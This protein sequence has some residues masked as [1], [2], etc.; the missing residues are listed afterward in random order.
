MFVLKRDGRRERVAFDKI[1][2]RINKLC[3]GL[4]S[5]FV[6]AAQIAQKVI[7][8]VYQGVTTVELDNLAA[9]TA[10][11]LT[12]T[13][14]DYAT[15]AARIAVSN[16]H[17]ETTKQFST[18]VQDL[19]SY[20]HPKTGLAQPMISTETYNTI[21][22]HAETLNAA[23]IYDRDYSYNY[24]GFK[25]LERSYLLKIDGMV[26]E[27]PQHMLMRVSVGIHGE[28]IDAAIETYN[29]LSERFFTHASPTLF[30][31]GTPHP[32]LSSCFLLT[33]KE[34]S[35]E[36]IYETL[37]SCAMISKSAGGIGINIHKIRASGSY[38]A[39]TN[40]HSNG[41]I[42]MLRVFNNTARYVDQGGNK[43]P[44]AFAIYL[45]PWHADIFDFLDLKKNTGKEENRARDLFYAMWICDLFM[46]RVEA[47][48]DWSLFCPSEAPGLEDC[49]GEKFEELYESYERK[50]LAR[51]VIKAQKLW[52]AIIE[53]Q[54]ETGTPYMLYKDAC[55][56]KS[57]Q[58]NLGTIKCSNLCTEIVEYTSPDEIAV[59]N[60]ASISLP[61]FV[62]D[63]N[64]YDFE[65]LRAVTKVMT[66][67]LN[68]VIDINFY[69]VIEAKNSNM[70]HRP[71][72]LGVQGLADAFIKMRLP[73][74]SAGAIALNKKIFENM[75]YAA[76][77]ASCEIAEKDGAYSTYEGSPM[78]KGIMQPDMWGIDLSE[79]DLDWPAL[80][81]K[82]AKFGVRNSLLM[83]PMPTAST[84]QILG[85]NECFEPYTS[86]I[87]TRRVLA[88]EFQIVNPH[89]L[90]DLTELNL[91]NETMKNRIIAENGS[92]QR[93]SAI[94]ADIKAIYKTVW[95]ISQK[96]I[97]D[98][99]A[100]RG[101]FIDQSQSLNIH[102][103]DPNYG[104]LT[105]MH[106][107]GWK[108]GL[109][110]GMYY[111]RTRP[112]VDAIKFT[113]DAEAVKRERAAEDADEQNMAAITCSID[114]RDACEMCSGMEKIVLASW[115]LANDLGYYN[116]VEYESHW[117]TLLEFIQDHEPTLRRAA[118]K[119]TIMASRSMGRSMKEGTLQSDLLAALSN[120]DTSLRCTATLALS[121]IVAASCTSC[122]TPPPDPILR[123]SFNSVF[124]QFLSVYPSTNLLDPATPRMFDQSEYMSAALTKQRVT[125][126][127][128]MARFF[129]HSPD[130]KTATFLEYMDRVL[131]MLVL[132][133]TNIYLKIAA[134][135]VLANYI[136]VTNLNRRRVEDKFVKGVKRIS[137]LKHLDAGRGGGGGSRGGVGERSLSRKPSAQSIVEGGETG[138][139]TPSLHDEMSVKDG[140]ES[141]ST[142]TSPGML[143][144]E[145]PAKVATPP[146]RVSDALKRLLVIEISKFWSVWFPKVADKN[147][148]LLKAKEAAIPV[149][150]EGYALRRTQWISTHESDPNVY[151]DVLKESCGVPEVVFFKDTWNW[152]A[153]TLDWMKPGYREAV[154][155]SEPQDVV[156]S[157]TPED[158]IVNYIDGAQLSF[159]LNPPMIVFNRYPHHRDLFL[160][161]RSAT[162]D[163]SFYLQASPPEFFSVTPSFGQILRGE[164]ITLK[165]YNIPALK[166]Y[167]DVIEFGI[168]PKNETRTAVV[169]LHSNVSIECPCLAL[170]SQSVPE[171]DCPFAVPFSWSQPLLLPKEK[172]SIKI[173]FK[174][175]ADGVFKEKL[176]II[177]MGGDV[178]SVDLKGTGGPTIKVSEEKLDMGPT[179][180]Y[181]N[182]V[183]RRIFVENKDPVNEI[184][185]RFHVSTDEIEVNHCSDL[186]LS[187]GEVK[188]VNVSFKSKFTGYRHE[189][190]KITAPNAL[191][192]PIAVVAVSGPAVLIP[193]ME[194]I[195]FPATIAGAASSVYIPIRNLSSSP[196]H[197]QISMPQN[198][199]FTIK[200]IEAENSVISKSSIEL[201]PFE[202]AEASGCSVTVTAHMTAVLQIFF[203]SSATGTFRVQLT[204]STV[205]PKKAVVA[206]HFLNAVSINES[207]MTRETPLPQIRKFLASPAREKPSG[208]FDKKAEGKPTNVH[209]KTSQVFEMDPPIQMCFGAALKA[210][211]ENIWEYVTLTNLVDSVQ[212]Y[213]LL[214]SAPF[215]TS[216]PLE[217][218][219]EPFTSL[220]IPLRVNT[221]AFAVESNVD[222]LDKTM[223]G[224]VAAFDDAFGVVSSGIIGTVGDLVAAEIRKDTDIIQF[225]PVRSPLELV[226]EGRVVAASSK[227]AARNVGDENLTT[228]T[229]TEWCPFGVMVSR[230]NLKP[231]DY[232]TVEIHFQATSSG[233]YSGRLMMTYV[234][235]VYHIINNEYHRTRVKRD[236]PSVGVQCAVGAAEIEL[237]KEPINFGDILNFIPAE[238]SLV[239]HN[240]QMIESRTP[241]MSC[242]PFRTKDSIVNVPKEDSLPLSVYF[243]SGKSKFYNSF[244]WLSSENGTTQTVPILANAGFSLLTTNLAEPLPCEIDEKEDTQVN[245]DS[246]HF[247]EFGFVGQSSSKMKVLHL[248]N[249]GTFEMIVKNIT[250]KDNSH[251]LWK[252][253]DE[254]DSLKQVTAGFQEDSVTFW[255]EKEVDWD[256]ID[257]KLSDEKAGVKSVQN[258]QVEAVKLGKKKRAS[259][260]VTQNV[261]ANQ[262]LSIHKQFPIRIAPLQ[263]LS[264]AIGFGGGKTLSEI[265]FKN[266]GTYALTWT[267]EP[268]GIK[269]TALPK[270]NPEPLP[271]NLNAIAPP[272]SIFPMKGV[273]SP[274]ATQVVEVVFCPNLPEY[275]VSNTFCL[276]TE[277]FDQKDII[278]RGIGASSNLILDRD[279]VD[280]DPEEGILEGNG[281]VD[282][283]VTFKPMGV[284]KINSFLKVIPH[285]MERYKL[286]PMVVNIL[287][288]A[289]YPDI[290]VLTKVVDFGTALFGAENTKPIVIENMGS[291]DADIIFTCS[292]PAISLE[293]GFSGAVVLPAKSRKDIKLIY[294][295]QQ[296]ELLNV[297][298]FVRSSDTR[299]DHFM[300]QLRGSV[301][302]PKITFQPSSITKEVNFGVCAV[303]GHQKRTF[304]MKNE[305]NINLTISMKIELLSIVYNSNGVQRPISAKTPA[306]VV[307][308]QSAILP[309]GEE[310]DVTVIFSPEK[311]AIYEYKMIFKYDFKQVSTILRGVGGRALFQIVSPLRRLDFGI[312]RLNRVFRKLITV[313]NTGNLGVGFHVRPE[314]ATRD[315]VDEDMFLNKSDAGTANHWT[316]MLE[317]LGVKIINPDGFCNASDK[318]DIILEYFPK[319]EAGISFRLRVYFDSEHED[320]D[321]L[322]SA[323]EP[324]L[325][326]MNN[327]NEVLT[328]DSPVKQATL[329]LG[330]HPINLEYVTTLK[331]VNDGPF[332]LDFLIQ[333]IGI[334]EFDIF[335]LRGYIEPQSSM[336]LKIFFNPTSESKF[337]VVLKVLWEGQPLRVNIVGSGGIGKLEVV[338]VEDKDIH[339]RCLDFNM[340]PFNSNA[341]KRFFLYNIGLVAVEVTADSDNPDYTITKTGDPFVFQRGLQRSGP[342]KNAWN[343]WSSNL[344]FTLLP[345]MGIE[346]GAKFFSRSP[347]TV[348]GHIL[349]YS[350][351]CELAIPMRG[352]GGTFSIAHRGELS[353]GDIASNYTYRRKLTV[354]N[355]G[356]IPANISLEW[357]IV[358]RSSEAASSYV[359][360]AEVYNNT[361]PR[362][363]F[364]R[365]DF[366][367]EN[368]ITASD[369]KLTAKD[370]WKLIGKIIRKPNVAGDDVQ[371]RTPLE[372][373]DAVIA[374]SRGSKT[375]RVPGG[376]SMRTA[377]GSGFAVKKLVSN[378]YST[379]I[380]RRQTFFHLITSTPVSSQSTA[381][382]SSFIKVEP[383]ACVLPSYG[384]VHLVVE[385]NL[386]TEDTFLAT[387]LI[388]S[389]IACS[390]PHEIT[391]SA[392][393]KAVSIV[394]DDTRMLNFYRQPLGEPEI[395]LRS[396]TNVGH[397][398]INWRI[399]NTNSALSI[400]PA[401]GILKIGQSQQVQFIFRPVDE[402]I[403]NADIIFEPDCSQHIRLKMSGGGGFAKASLS[404]Y[405]RFD[406]GHC[407]IGKD[408]ISLLPITNE[409]NALLHLTRFDLYETDTFF[410]GVD[411]PTTRISLFPGQSFNLAL[412]FNPHEE[413]PSAGRLVIGTSSESWEIELI[414]LGR[415]AVLIVSKS[416]LEFTDCLIGNS[417]ERK[418]GLK[419]VGD[420]NYPVTFT[421]E[422]EFPDLEFI[423]PSLVIN[424][425]SENSV[426]ISYTPTMSIKSTVVM[427]VS[428]P[429]S[430]HKIPIHLHSGTATLEFT[431]EELDFGMFERVTRP[432]LKLGI[433]NTGSV[434]TS[435]IVRD[436]VKPSL[437]Q[438]TGGRGLLL[439]GKSAEVTITHVRHTVADFTETLVIKSDLIDSFYYVKVK[440]QCEESLLKP[441]EFSLLNLGVCPVL[442][443]TTK[444]LSFKNY[445]MFP[446]DFNVKST[447]PLKV[448]PLSGRVMGG[449][450]T[451]VLV[452]WSPSGGY[453]LRTQLTLATNIG[454]YNVIVRGKAAFPELFIKNVYLDFGVCGVG[455]PYSEK[456]HMV[457]KGKVPLHFNIPP[458]RELSYSVSQPTGYLDL[459]ESVAL[460]VI[461]KP[462]SVGRFAHSFIVECKGVSYK[463]VVVVGIGG[464]VRLDISPPH[465]DLGHSPC[466][467]RVYHVITLTNSGEVVLNVDWA[468]LEESEEPTCTI[469]LPDPVTIMP[470]RAA[471]CI[472]GATAHKIGPISAKLVVKTKEKSHIVPVSGSGVRIIL[473]EKSRRILESEHLPILEATGPFGKEIEIKSVE[474]WFKQI[475]RKRLVTDL[476]IVESIKEIMREARKREM[477][478]SLRIEEIEDDEANSGNEVK[479]E[480]VPDSPREVARDEYLGTNKPLP[481]IQPSKQ[482]PAEA[483]ASSSSS[484]PSTASAPQR[485]I[486]TPPKPAPPQLPKPDV[487]S[488]RGSLIVGPEITRNIS[489][490]ITA[491]DNS[492]AELLD[493]DVP[494][495]T[496]SSAAT[497][498]RKKSIPLPPT[499]AFS[500]PSRDLQFI[501]KKEGMLQSLK[502][503]QTKAVCM[504]E[505]G[506]I[507]QEFIELKRV[508]REE[509]KPIPSDYIIQD[510][511]DFGSLTVKPR[512]N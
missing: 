307:E 110:T 324:K 483:E 352:K 380:K 94:P 458:M 59:C 386:S 390:A 410:K 312:C 174:P 46:K 512:V 2:A 160:Q 469:F 115:V 441:D 1:T 172:K 361:D 120:E 137:D 66:K 14:P 99:A 243:Q 71:V 257:F 368:N 320:I 15:L 449:D 202:T 73:F 274:G 266:E 31:A 343:N 194:D 270:Y 206:T 220:D 397:K 255:E 60:L 212:K 55:N 499:A 491:D 450:S 288:T 395:L 411:W 224:Q 80:R 27:R 6:D 185:V 128:A 92:I 460:D 329:D 485:K 188:A 175:T 187:P 171:Q 399:I 245:V 90:K 279:S 225:N 141:R 104:K 305:G 241:L 346:L 135:H 335:P 345:A 265:K 11:Y 508:S 177:A 198:S 281:V 476:Q 402:S 451:S 414:G 149:L 96:L 244:L 86:N 388:K 447:Y 98:M 33:M 226:W 179:D 256:E 22:K 334:R 283:V 79:S 403:Q 466:D 53:S 75:Y 287:G 19:Y 391:L 133:E 501:R 223:I 127:H 180:I 151:N 215:Y 341:E 24:F 40:G 295:P 430:S 360:L 431:S 52:Y 408:T 290:M 371:A 268:K 296:I 349:L 148:D 204:T 196:A 401:R 365:S 51:K 415:E 37:K 321:I 231:F 413:S 235:P 41:I 261:V 125:Y 326:L 48:G 23:I 291:A 213:T 492:E 426:V 130:A 70:R 166:V 50:G 192:P 269:Y 473:T 159:S 100:D 277:D 398:D 118:L 489:V 459:K 76:V 146:S 454:N 377:N 186:M 249:H 286:K 311:L 392:T 496:A 167:P 322:A 106:F 237:D 208:V 114:N 217:G 370:Y 292:H 306:F 344:S 182:S 35:I 299:G 468:V 112:A 332:A 510:V 247:I 357:L 315:W 446:L 25:T 107:Y 195:I 427:T 176:Y 242:I 378:H 327:D 29:L 280:F 488:K 193:V 122:Q 310:M 293:G 342:K 84:S 480:S 123:H 504:D 363:G 383:G 396:F 393:P 303:K 385:I 276:K 211:S 465:V 355:S 358:G 168:C 20:S 340:V 374:S 10:A 158:P 111:L 184:P 294:C 222:N 199:P 369:Y 456:L 407:M 455:Y 318:T 330:V 219:I 26:A 93:I 165:A 131:Q 436:T 439:P 272:V 372:S 124:N 230:I 105:S 68:K 240:R 233:T 65:K 505:I 443:A 300:I 88:G 102:L 183:S 87:Y 85:N 163:L 252:F 308:P 43:R 350:D 359:K 214:L 62:I 487:L 472:F 150:S 486:A 30:N 17:K 9:E 493:E 373:T 81:E 412:V 134:V 497:S 319:V 366:L 442:D 494:D 347:T 239:L 32:Q 316:Q 8:G 421:L 313:S 495:Q 490:N 425:F 152:K 82:V 119:A 108:K 260:A 471:R 162:D 54:T 21:M 432:S 12:T 169:L 353:F 258:H 203:K 424:P 57:N 500:E 16:L 259:K 470:G 282:L 422:K 289:S 173:L 254:F 379:L 452:S 145:S 375:S 376:N 251:V 109:K 453:E 3:Y 404:K 271:A 67:N 273:V 58:Q 477:P 304:K 227:V 462:T 139:G 161:N 250:V 83:A 314:G 63:K 69:P 384:E 325:E 47:N 338:Y 132:P 78:S 478:S 405:R 423:P 333:P 367:R 362:S 348:V 140:M 474:H 328:S 143:G 337:Q 298:V 236:L 467:L 49:W 89:L 136:P 317:R 354:S 18:V 117:R 351:C 482:E 7:T 234:D 262:S 461:F 116:L 435:F 221:A 229:L 417:Y 389:D 28:D 420:V 178:Y 44:G 509:D 42:P 263:T 181:Y 156:D 381:L 190:F 189:S 74:E 205:K 147:L 498:R 201:R 438:L 339:S 448:T 285:S 39:G 511:I 429:Y 121:E 38:I 126:L 246:K 155:T 284:C 5:N 481:Q 440:G 164:S 72:G 103:A 36:G 97:I 228:T 464:V 382:T 506:Q 61:A 331:L 479:Q 502:V 475:S 200:L 216:V 13:H 433:K 142:I 232:A 34:D 138:L 445:G 409:G 301:G 309:I 507:S 503:V 218:E 406:F 153:K 434:K 144:V 45:E 154:Q 400:I 428:S 210:K 356:S 253:L 101:A 191:V 336:P 248:S 64:T 419:N 207:F 364:S 437:F 302:V 387:L 323:A 267:L 77:E 297:K 264:L 484:R 416:S 91:W 457:N 129:A 418:L 113:V 463:E 444:T 170:V 197:L 157:V 275:E 56:S 4:D 238:K 278:I 95:E 394:C 209:P